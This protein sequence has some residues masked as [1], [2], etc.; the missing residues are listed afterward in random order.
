[1]V[2]LAVP[3]ARD[4]DSLPEAALPVILASHV[5]PG[6]RVTQVRLGGGRGGGCRGRG[7]R[8]ALR[9]WQPRRERP[10]LSPAAAATGSASLPG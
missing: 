1:M 5:G 4:S 9:T 7:R 6:L 2:T 3:P 10:R 8:A